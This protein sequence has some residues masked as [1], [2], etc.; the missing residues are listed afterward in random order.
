MKKG[1]FFIALAFATLVALTQCFNKT[2]KA[3]KPAKDPSLITHRE[4]MDTLRRDSMAPLS[5]I[6]LIPIKSAQAFEVLK[7]IDLSKTIQSVYPDNGFFGKDNYRI[8]F[9]FSEVKKDSVFVNTYHVKGKN[10]HK[11]VITPFKGVIRI[12]DLYELFDPNL[13]TASLNA[14]EVLKVYGAKGTFVLEEDPSKPETSGTFAGTFS[15]EFSTHKNGENFLWFYSLETPLQGAGYRFDGNWTM[16]KNP[17]VVEPVL[18]ARDLFSFAND[19]LKDFSIGE[20]EVEVN[21]AY[22]HLGWE[23]F[24]SGEEWWNPS[25]KKEL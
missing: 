7:N 20:R 15:T 5:K 12:I 10:K 16:F 14:M 9:I 24:W 18:W 17:S 2:A 8:E 23:E 22:R 21:P 13:D 25:P 19:I 3:N 1:I 11:K 4:A 6:T